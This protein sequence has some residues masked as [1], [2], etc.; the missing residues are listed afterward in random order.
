MNEQLPT[1]R[2]LVCESGK[3][4]PTNPP[5]ITDTIETITFTGAMIRRTDQFFQKIKDGEA[6]RSFK[7]STP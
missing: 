6:T 4:L 5:L 3:R 1:S 7:G 2:R